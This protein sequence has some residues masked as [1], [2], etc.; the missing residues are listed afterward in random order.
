MRNLFGEN[1]TQNEGI[2]VWYDVRVKH[3]DKSIAT[4][5]VKAFNRELAKTLVFEAFSKKVI[6]L[7]VVES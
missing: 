1:V 4:Y 7:A 3:E 2:E 5:A 6:I